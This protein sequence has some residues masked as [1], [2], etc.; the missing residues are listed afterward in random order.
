MS[1]P[2]PEQRIEE[3]RSLI[4]SH[5]KTYYELNNLTISD[6]EWDALMRELIQLEELHP[7]LRNT[8]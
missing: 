4:R 3:L 8:N 2:D 6:V 5:N 1:T 7:S